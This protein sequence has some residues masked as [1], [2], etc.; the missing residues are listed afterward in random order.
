MLSFSILL[1]SSVII[2]SLAAA[3]VRPSSSLALS[4]FS[5]SSAP[6]SLSTAAPVR[7][8]GAASPRHAPSHRH[9][10]GLVQS[11]L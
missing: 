4:V 2:V 5:L 8:P 9:F 10:N 3:V 11:L 6:V 7:D 1:T